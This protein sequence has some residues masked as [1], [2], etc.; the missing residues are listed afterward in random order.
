MLRFSSLFIAVASI[1]SVFVGPFERAPEAGARSFFTLGHSPILGTSP[2]S[3]YGFDGTEV[4]F[5]LP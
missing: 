3:D 1:V 2:I 4:A 5:A